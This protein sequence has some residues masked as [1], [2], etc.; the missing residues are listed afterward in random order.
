M[1]NRKILGFLSNIWNEVFALTHQEIIDQV[2][3]ETGSDAQA[4]IKNLPPTIGSDSNARFH[5]YLTNFFRQ[6]GV[7]YPARYLK[8]AIEQTTIDIDNETF[9]GRGLSPQAL[10]ML[11]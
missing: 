9:E 8:N 3:Q 1:L 2:A 5:R 6:G 10:E 4:F 7:D 11:T